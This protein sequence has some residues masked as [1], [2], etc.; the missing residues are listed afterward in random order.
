MG[1]TLTWDRGTVLIEGELPPELK[2]LSFIKFDDRVGKYRSLAIYYPRILAAA[3]SLGL[4][5]DDR[6]WTPHCAEVRVAAEVKLRPY[7][8]RAL[9]AW[10]RTKRGVVVM[11]TGAGKTHVAIA[12]IATLKV[13]ALVVVPT[14]EL[15]QQWRAKLQHHFPGRVGVWYGE[16][17]RES[18]VTVIT[19]D[20]AYGA[21]ESIGNKY[22]LLIFD[23]VHHLPS[24]S[25]R[26]I[27]ELSPAPYRMGLTATPERADGLHVDLDWLVGP[28]AYR[29]SPAE[30]RGTWT[31]DYDVEVVRVGLTEEEQALYKEYEKRYLSYVRRRGLRFRSPSDFQILVRL[32]GRDQ[33]A[34]KALEAWH[35]M[36]RLVLETK[37]KVKAVGE[38]LARHP[39]SKVL[40]FT[41]YTTLARAVSER[42]L[43]PLVTHDMHPQER[44]LVMSMFKR[45]EVRA[46]VTGK[47]LDEGVDVPDVDVVVILGG[48]SSVR[49]FIQRM[50]RALRF[51]PH[52]AKIYEVV[53]SGTREVATARRR[54]RGV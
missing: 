23:E 38:I 2:R 13:P 19:Y 24:P 35:A 10:L 33:E 29:L 3:R 11:P 5:V 21:V 49:Q 30:V 36:R 20:S 53:T 52:K 27:A 54:K 7:Q 40:I 4:G 16:E 26:Q 15:V 17:K 6:V 9:E 12:A 28:V 47:V 42:Y 14:V 44:D 8:Q 37:A 32:A 34:R 45:G 1:I 31:A 25:Y 46:L 22:Q 43:I 51:K 41:E 48:T 50:G 39:A 18:C